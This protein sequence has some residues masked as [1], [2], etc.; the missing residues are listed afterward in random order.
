MMVGM[1]RWMLGFL[2]GPFPGISLFCFAFAESSFFPIPPDVM[3]IP[4][5]IA[6]PDRFVYY[7]SL[8]T[9][10][11][12]L[13]GGLGYYIG[14]RGGR[15]LLIR[16]FAGPKVDLVEHYY[17]RYN[18]WATGI[19]GLTPIPYKLFTIGAGTFKVN[20]KIFMVAS[21]LSRG[22]R[23]FTVAILC[24]YFGQ[25]IQPFI[26]RYF[27]WI[28]VIFVILLL[29]GFWAVGMIAKKLHGRPE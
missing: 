14:V 15:P 18:A 2:E 16:F 9:L 12:V 27:N 25:A 5:V 24:Y 3:L 22:A 4:L 17:N 29:G 26:K 8:T 7:A 10:G 6:E 23:F 19:A 20:F 1:R 13:G 11:S 21:I 28:S